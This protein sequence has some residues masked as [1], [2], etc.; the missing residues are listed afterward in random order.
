MANTFLL[1]QGHSVGASLVEL[2]FKS[3]AKRILAKAKNKGCTILLP[4]DVMVR[5]KP[6]E[7]AQTAALDGG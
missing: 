2:T 3:T 5:L 1:A 6:S 7:A 4:T